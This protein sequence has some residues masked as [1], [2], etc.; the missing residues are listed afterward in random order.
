MYLKIHHVVLIDYLLVEPAVRN[1]TD[2]DTMIEKSTIK[3]NFL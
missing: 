2:A 1:V 3:N